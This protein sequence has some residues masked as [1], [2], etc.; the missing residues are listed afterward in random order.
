MANSSLQDVPED[1]KH[2]RPPPPAQIDWSKSPE[3]I[4]K[5]YMKDHRS[6]ISSAVASVAGTLSG[7][8]TRKAV[9]KMTT[10][11]GEI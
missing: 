1:K 5:T 9:V 7:V 4:V 11:N 8:G 3:H 6:A 2:R 10:A